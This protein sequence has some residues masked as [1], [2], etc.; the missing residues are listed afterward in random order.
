MASRIEIDNIPLPTQE[1]WKFIDELKKPR[2]RY[3]PWS[4]RTATPGEAD[5]SKGTT[6]I[7][8]F[9]DPEGRLTTALEDW[10]KFQREGGLP[11]N[12]PYRVEL[13]QG[14]CGPFDSFRIEIST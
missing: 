5:F 14:D 9:P 11:E 10:K 12:G 1:N 4:R 2:Q 7:D 13:R 3:F 8:S 6:V